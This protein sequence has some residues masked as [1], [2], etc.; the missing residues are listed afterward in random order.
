MVRSSSNSSLSAA[1]AILFLC[2]LRTASAYQVLISDQDEVRQVCTGMWG[3]GSQDAFI[4]GESKSGG[5]PPAAEYKLTRHEHAVLFSPSSRGQLALVIFEWQDAKYLGVDPSAE[6]TENHWSE[7]VR[8]AS[9][10]T[11]NGWLANSA[12]AARLHLHALCSLG[13]PVH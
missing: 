12:L 11:S 4:E 3:K 5:C 9:L 13:Q 6:G 1:L 8:P 2:L 10:A 7:E